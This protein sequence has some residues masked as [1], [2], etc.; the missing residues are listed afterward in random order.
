[1]RFTAAITREGRWYVA[2]CIEIEV[3]SQGETFESALANLK[4]AI[5]LRIE[6]EPDIAGQSEPPII[7]SVEVLP[8]RHRTVA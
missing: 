6:D 2:R 7:A 5:E 8:E 4:E 1:M 3:A